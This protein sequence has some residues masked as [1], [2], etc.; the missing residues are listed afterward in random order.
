MEPPYVYL[1]M[2]RLSI[3]D[4]RTLLCILNTRYGCFNMN[5]STRALMQAEASQLLHEIEG[6]MAAIAVRLYGLPFAVYQKLL[7]WFREGKW[8]PSLEPSTMKSK[9]RGD[10]YFWMAKTL[11]NFAGLKRSFAFIE[12]WEHLP[13]PIEGVSQLTLVIVYVM[14]QGEKTHPT[15]DDIIARLLECKIP[16]I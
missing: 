13:K 11:Y 9:K 14:L 16:I 1:E 5:H 8:E 10:S 3:R 7:K 2:S 12:L 15:I 4:F 6:D